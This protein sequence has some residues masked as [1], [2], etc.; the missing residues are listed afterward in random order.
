[1]ANSVPVPLTEIKRVASLLN[2]NSANVP[3]AFLNIAADGAIEIN[4]FRG[5]SDFVLSPGFIVLLLLDEY[6]EEAITYA[7]RMVI[8]NQEGY[9][10]DVS[11]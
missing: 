2:E 5:R 11:S 4:W 3:Q 8:R 1:M 7:I 6:S 9:Y 10:V